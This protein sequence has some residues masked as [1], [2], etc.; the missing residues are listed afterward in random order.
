MIFWKILDTYYNTDFPQNTHQNLFY[1]EK[2]SIKPERGDVVS[3][4]AHYCNFLCS[5]PKNR[6]KSGSGG[7]CLIDRQ[8]HRYMSGRLTT[9]EHF[10][11]KIFS[12]PR[13][14]IAQFYENLAKIACI[15]RPWEN[16][17]PKIFSSKNTRKTKLTHQVSLK[18]DLIKFWSTFDHWRSSEWSKL[19]FDQKF[20]D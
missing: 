11:T 4:F 14:L 8:F 17:G 10:H 1:L 5:K 3:F 13:D 18:S 15:S 19:F 12:T 16:K 6:E 9:C 20:V 2:L 7:Q